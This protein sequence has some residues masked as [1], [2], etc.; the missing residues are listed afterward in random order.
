MF[1]YF[2]FRSFRLIV[3][4]CQLLLSDKVTLLPELPCDSRASTTAK[5]NKKGW[6]NWA[7]TNRSGCRDIFIRITCP[8]NEDP[9]TPHVH[10]I[11]RGFTGVL[12]FSYLA[13]KH[14]S[15]VLVRR[16]F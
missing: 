15:W 5:I 1:L 16:R 14:R 11:K 9:L 13:L 7:L 8:C 6:R 4:G 10:I 2:C 12:S 3:M